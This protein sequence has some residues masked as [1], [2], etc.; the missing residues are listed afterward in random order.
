MPPRINKTPVGLRINRNRSG[1]CRHF[2]NTTA[3]TLWCS[4]VFSDRFDAVHLRRVTGTAR[5]QFYLRLVALDEVARVP[6]K[7]FAGLTEGR[8]DGRLPPRIMRALGT[9][10][11]RTLA[12][13]PLLRWTEQKILARASSNRGR[14]STMQP[15]SELGF[16][17]WF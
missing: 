11:R 13:C 5:C 12:F 6:K 7:M 14:R 9:R 4:P 16:E 8:R 1:I 15:D 17:F 2:S 10:I 3:T